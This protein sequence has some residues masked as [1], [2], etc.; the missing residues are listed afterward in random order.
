MS[1]DKDLLRYID[2]SLWKPMS[3]I[4]L[5]FKLTRLAYSWSRV[6]QSVNF[7]ILS[8]FFILCAIYVFFFF[9]MSA[10]ASLHI[11]C[12]NL[13]QHSFCSCGMPLIS[14]ISPLCSRLFLFNCPFVNI[15]IL[16]Y[17]SISFSLFIVWSWYF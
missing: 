4:D 13:M 14:I 5:F 15:L 10:A 8:P 3:L 16:F 12:A 7:T 9:L 6:G 2:V 1:N 11:W 17:W